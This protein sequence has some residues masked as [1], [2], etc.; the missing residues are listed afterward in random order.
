MQLELLNDQGQASSKVDAPDTVFGRD[1]NEALIHQIVVAYQA[2]ARQGTRAQKDRQMVKHSTKK[3]FRQ[4]GTGRARAGMTSSP[5]WRGGGRIFPNSPDENFS[6]KVNKKMYRAGMASIFSQLARD[7]RIAVVDSLTI[8]APK[9]K[10]LAAKFKAMGFGADNKTSVLVIADDIDENLFL[11]SRNLANVMVVE[12][13]Y[14]DPLSLVF[15][16]KVLVTKGA[17]DKLQEMFS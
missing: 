4:K 13:R 3:P 9:T 2:N 12:P 11:A 14:A 16:K 7:G 17:I 8:D 5:L 10:L 15:Y 6:H 1:Y